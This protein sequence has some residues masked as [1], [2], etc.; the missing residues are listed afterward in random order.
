[1]TSGLA[2]VMG[3]RRRFQGG[4]LLEIGRWEK[5]KKVAKVVDAR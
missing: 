5:V 2:E 1:M 4:R 3:S